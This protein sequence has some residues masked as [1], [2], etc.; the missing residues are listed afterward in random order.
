M[1]DLSCVSEVE[2]AWFDSQ[3]WNVD[4]Y[5]D[6]DVYH[7][8]DDELPSKKRRTL[9]DYVLFQT[10][11]SLHDA[12]EVIKSLELYTYHSTSHLKSATRLNYLCKFDTKCL[13]RLFILLPNYNTDCQ[14]FKAQHDHTHDTNLKKHGIKPE[15]KSK[16]VDLYNRGVVKPKDILRNLVID[17]VFPL[18]YT[19]TEHIS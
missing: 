1:M 6:Y 13:S 9:I 15:I 8:D 11:P 16:I 12:K 7:E 17:K 4:E 5:D 3:A 2:S 10:C 19:R 14:V 18:Y